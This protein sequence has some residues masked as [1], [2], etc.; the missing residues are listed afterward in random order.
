MKI[1]LTCLFLF[2]APVFAGIGTGTSVPGA[3]P[4]ELTSFT[5][6][7]SGSVV[8]LR[9]ATETEVNNYGFEIERASSLSSLISGLGES[10]LCSGTWQQ[11]QPKRIF[12]YRYSQWRIK[13]SVSP[14]TN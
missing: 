1:L 7:F 8:E 5:A 14:K 3:L 6:N 11:Q 10:W 4:V 2:S 13:I 12:I 9:W